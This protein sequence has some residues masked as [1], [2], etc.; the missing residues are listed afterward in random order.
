MIGIEP[1]TFFDGLAGRLESAGFEIQR[2]VRSD[3]YLLDI[4]A[5]GPGI[6][7]GRHP[8]T[9]AL[10]GIGISSPT[11][12]GV[13][14]FSSFALKYVL[15]NRKSLGIPTMDLDV[16]PVVVSE[17]I[18]QEVI[19]WISENS[20]LQ[21]ALLDRFEFPVLVSTITGEIYCYMKTPFMGGLHHRA[22]RKW[23]STYVGFQKPAIGP[24]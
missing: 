9:I 23:A 24:T 1:G 20:P 6:P 14:A 3:P 2:K 12:T 15:D 11:P 4:F 22:L 21:K 8:G 5:V 16:V 17:A 19:L 13:S 18:N 10:L 7:R